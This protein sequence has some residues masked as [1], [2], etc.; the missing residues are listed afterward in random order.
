M[1]LAT[2]TDLIVQYKYV[3]MIPIAFIEGPI[4]AM[5]CGILIH[6]GL[7]ALAPTFILLYCVDLVGDT[8]WYWLGRLWGHSFIRRFGSYVSLTE[9]HV[10]TVRK[11]FHKYH[12]GIL[13]FSKLTMGL[14]FPGATLFTAGL[15]HIPYG[16]YMAINATGQLVWTSFLLSVGYFLGTYME[17]VNNVFGIVSTGAII[18]I[19]LVLL[20]GFSKFVRARITRSI[21]S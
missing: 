15:S 6:M 20:I 19:V 10:E 9:D 7:L 8:M 1:D 13:F 17:R 14:G 16:K 4:L 3:I 11:I 5:L 12:V 18:I 2:V 21:S